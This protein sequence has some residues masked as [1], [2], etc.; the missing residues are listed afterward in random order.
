MKYKLFLLK[1]LRYEI[2]RELFVIV[3]MFRNRGGTSRIY[4]NITNSQKWVILESL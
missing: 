3:V 2:C 1:A 4:E